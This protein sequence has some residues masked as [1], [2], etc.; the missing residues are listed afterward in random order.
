M[1]P[2]FLISFALFFYGSMAY[3]LSGSG[4][5]TMPEQD[6]RIFFLRANNVVFSYSNDQKQHSFFIE[7]NESSVFK[8]IRSSSFPQ[9]TVTFQSL[10]LDSEMIPHK[11]DNDEASMHFLDFITSEIIIQNSHIGDS[12]ALEAANEL[13]EFI[14]QLK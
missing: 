13:Y 10:V 7:E 1:M 5:G 11:N 3:T 8:T 14:L 2:K 12:E 6:S 9:I 4:G